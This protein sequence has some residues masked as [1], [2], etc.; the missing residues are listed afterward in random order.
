MSQ[1]KPTGGF[2][3]V[4]GQGEQGLLKSWICVDG[5]C[6]EIIMP[7]GSTGEQ[8]ATDLPLSKNAQKRLLKA[9]K[10]EELRAGSKHISRMFSLLIFQASTKNKEERK[11][12]GEAIKTES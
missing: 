1:Q 11:K 12:S 6:F 3:S 4:R 8:G 7:D 10:L 9:A 2:D 5:D